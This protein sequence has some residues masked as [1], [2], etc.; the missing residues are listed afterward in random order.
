MCAISF[1][2]LFIQACLIQNAVGVCLG[3]TGIN[4]AVVAP[5]AG[6][7]IAPGRLGYEG[8]GSYGGVGVGNIRVAGELPVVGIT[9]VAGRVPIVGTVKFEGPAC[10]GGCVTIA[11]Q[12]TP[13]CGWGLAY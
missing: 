3:K 8:C 1:I 10:A 12:C 6:A 5:L 13:I 9:S 2:L 11:G 4:N 7:A